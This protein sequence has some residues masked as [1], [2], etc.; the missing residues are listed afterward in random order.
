M[1]SFQTI[2]VSIMLLIIV[3]GM[4]GYGFCKRLDL[5]QSFYGWYL[6]GCFLLWA[7][8]EIIL[9]PM[10]Y[11]HAGFI[12]ACIA[13]LLLYILAAG[14]GFTM[15]KNSNRTALNPLVRIKA[16]ARR[17]FHREYLLLGIN[18]LITF[19][20]ICTYFFLQYDNP[21]D[22]HYI[23][24]AAD[25]LKSGRLFLSNN[26]T[27][28][29]LNHIP[30]VY[31]ADLA[32][33]WSFTYAFL[34][35]TA[36]T[37]PLI[38]A[39]IILPVQLLLLCS[40]TY[41]TLSEIF[42]YKNN[43]VRLLFMAIVWAC[44]FS[45]I[46]SDYSSEA[47]MMTR[48]WQ[49]PALVACLGI[50]AILL[51]FLHIFS[52]P[53]SRKLWCLLA[54]F[55]LALCFM[56]RAGVILALI[57]IPAFSFIDTMIYKEIRIMIRGMVI[58]L[59]NVMYWSLSDHIR[60]GIHYTGDPSA[61]SIF[62]KLTESLKSCYGDSHLIVLGICCAVILSIISEK[63]NR[64]LIYPLLAVVFL[65]FYP[66]FYGMASAGMASWSM[67]WLLPET[68]IIGITLT[69]FIMKASSRKNKTGGL[70][71]IMV[72]L[73]ISGYCSNG[74]KAVTKTANLEKVNPGHKKI[75]DYILSRSDSPTCLMTSSLLYEARQ[76]AP[77]IKLAY[78]L[79]ED[80]SVSMIDTCYY[81]LPHLMEMPFLGSYGIS[82]I[83]RH[84]DIDYIVVH[85]RDH[86]RIKLL[87]SI[88]F[89][90][91]KRIG[92]YLIYYHYTPEEFAL[93]QENMHRLN[94]KVKRV[95][96]AVK[97][98]DRLK[99]EELT[100]EMRTDN[101]D[102]AAGQEDK[103]KKEENQ[104][105]ETASTELTDASDQTSEESTANEDSYDVEDFS[106]SSSE[107]EEEDYQDSSTE[108]NDFLENPPDEEDDQDNSS[109]EEDDQDSFQRYY[110]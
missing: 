10:T 47:Q 60:R 5:F 52:K 96:R 92:N 79:N 107:E 49:G 103:D 22:V 105:A 80:G 8:T 16:R 18:A 82:R 69:R 40:C 53:F 50:P 28:Q 59:P 89:N 44:L 57:M 56:D 101:T 48:I 45:G 20:A 1:I 24:S 11:F 98:L 19:A 84:S 85:V 27:G 12:Q 104:D 54:V 41:L 31:S 108:E 66:V 100:A 99:F 68:V 6:T 39:H 87:R 23:V 97:K 74:Y 3:P 62:K 94:I 95:Y 64:R 67:L 36:A 76:Y 77:E 21:G 29:V 91:L 38:A 71:I 78:S 58:C 43:L 14:Y 106:D 81:K 110:N 61:A 15:Y 86:M 33:P 83:V 42:F 90:L 46:F 13:V 30:P 37:S 2:T 25:I 88:R 9:V 109:E 35:G 17:R 55:D 32:S 63:E 34:A 93:Y 73:F 75:Y 51:V 4:A 72:L 26:A 65:I 7:G 70:L 102:E